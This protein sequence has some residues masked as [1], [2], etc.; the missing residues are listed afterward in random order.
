MDLQNPI[1][2]W[3]AANM[4]PSSAIAAV[5]FFISLNPQAEELGFF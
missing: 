3:L 2:D 1:L 4:I 5:V